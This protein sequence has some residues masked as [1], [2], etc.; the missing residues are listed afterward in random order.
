M[1]TGAVAAAATLVLGLSATTAS[2]QSVPPGL[3]VR[4]GH[5][6]F[7]AGYAEGTQNYICIATK[8]GMA[9]RFLGPQA[10]LFV[11]EIGA[12]L[13]QI[14]THFLSIDP[15]ATARPTW[16]HSSDSSRVW[17]R[18]IASSTDPAY[19]AEGAIPWLLLE[20]ANTAVGPAN[21]NTLAQT[22]FIQR[23]NTSGGRQPS[24]GCSQ[25][26]HIGAMALVPYTTDYYFYR[27]SED[28]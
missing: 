9:W 24:T 22:T 4:A 28:R 11:S 10:T 1:K 19:V 15:D 27:A 26:S 8:G 25:A 21:G 23:L 16:Q 7:M 13:Q 3:E 6:L 17:G 2:A 12:P 14:S 18:V 20:A 5:E